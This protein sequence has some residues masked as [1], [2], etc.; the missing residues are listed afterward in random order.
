MP[1]RFISPVGTGIYG[2]FMNSEVLKQGGTPEIEVDEL[3][4]VN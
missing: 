4:Y 1:Y 3:I 2:P